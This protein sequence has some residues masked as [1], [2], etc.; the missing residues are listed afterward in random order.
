MVRSIGND[1][2]CLCL[3]WR[4]SFC[5]FC[6]VTGWWMFASWGCCSG[7]QE[8]KPR[9]GNYQKGFRIDVPSCG[10][11]PAGFVDLLSPS[12]H[13]LTWLSDSGRKRVGAKELNIRRRRNN[14]CCAPGK[15]RLGLKPNDVSS[16]SQA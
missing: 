11:D 1:L 9:E 10:G 6:A 15:L 13:F 12:R 7:E 5:F 14:E 16:A 8:N 4:C 3:S 2:I